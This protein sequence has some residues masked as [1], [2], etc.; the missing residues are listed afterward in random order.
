[1][2]ICSKL[3]NVDPV[4]R[5]HSSDGRA[6]MING[7]TA[8]C[9]YSLLLADNLVNKGLCDATGGRT[10]QLSR[11]PGKSESTAVSKGR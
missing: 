1:M 9:F 8:K 11:Y 7:I 2:M 4:V 10:C 3:Q 6:V 5:T